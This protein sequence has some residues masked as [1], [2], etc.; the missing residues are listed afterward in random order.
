[1]KK[2]EYM[3]VANYN[4]YESYSSK[5]DVEYLNDRGREG[6][7]LVSIKGG[8]AIFVREKEA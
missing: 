8:E 3:T 5:I 1:M 4:L 7:Q 6:W 2:Y